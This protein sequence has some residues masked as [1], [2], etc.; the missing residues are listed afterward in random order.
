MATMADGLE[1]NGEVEEPNPAG[2]RYLRWIG[3]VPLTLAPSVSESE[4]SGH[5]A[6]DRQPTWDDH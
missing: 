5:S 2:V 4:A 3:G 1:M 6:L